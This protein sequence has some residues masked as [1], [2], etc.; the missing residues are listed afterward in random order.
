M[1]PSATPSP[2]AVRRVRVKD[3]AT[4]VGITS[5]AVRMRL[6]MFGIEACGKD[7]RDK[8]YLPDDVYRA[9]PILAPVATATATTE[10]RTLQ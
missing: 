1:T 5:S 7:G 10:P 6:A 3:I 8:L 2:I 4:A 9:F